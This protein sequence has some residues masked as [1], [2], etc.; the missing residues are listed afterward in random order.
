[1]NT[2]RKYR[3]KQLWEAL[4]ERGLPWTWATF[5][6]ECCSG[7]GPPSCGYFG[8]APLYNLDE[9]VAWFEA[10]ISPRKKRVA[11]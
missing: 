6:R 4:R 8:L 3:R 5:Q 2:D 1:M 9:A 7:N 11:A 10:G